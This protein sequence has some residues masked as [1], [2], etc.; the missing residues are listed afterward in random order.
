MSRAAG[1]FAVTL[2]VAATA[3]AWA[4]PISITTGAE[5]TD[6]E[7]YAAAELGD[8]LSRLTAEPISRGDGAGTRL[9]VG[10]VAATP[11]LKTFEPPVPAD[12]AQQEILIRSGTVGGTPAV[13]V[14]GGSPQAVLWAA[15]EL[16]EHLGVVFEFSGEILPTNTGPP[17]LSGIDIRRSPSIAERGLRLHLNFPMDQSAYS[18]PDFLTWVDRIARMKY[19]YLMLHFYAAHPW[20]HFKYRDAET[21]TGTFFVGSYMFGGRYD[22]PPDMIGRELIHNQA[23]FFP[24]EMEGMQQGPAL[25]RKTQERIRAVIDRAHARGIKVA[26]SFE[27]LGLPGDIGSHMGEW[28]KQAGGRDQLMR[29]VTT[30][31]L[32]ACMD[33]YPQADEYQLIS[34]EGSNDAPPGADLKAELR[35]LCA[36]YSIPFDPEDEGTFAG[37]RQ[38]G[39]N[40]TPYN[41]PAVS[42]ELEKG[43][44]RPVV[45]TLRFVDLALDVLA[46]PAVSSRMQREGKQGNVGIYLPH[47]NAVKLCTPALRAMMPDDARLQMMVDYGAR[48]TADQMPG[49]E[50]LRGANMQLGVITWL[51]FDGS[52]FLPQAWPRSVYDCVKSSAGLPLTT[53]VAN[54]WRVSGLE[55]DAACLAQTPWLVGESYGDWL[56]GYLDRLFGQQGAARAGEAYTALEDATLYCRAHLF[57][58]G[59]CWEGRYRQGFGYPPE[60]LGEARRRFERAQGGFRALARTQPEGGAKRRADYLA[61]RCRC[62]MVHLDT[63]RELAQAQVQPDDSPQRIAAC[64]DHALRARDLAREYMTTYAAFVLDRGDEGMLV[65]YH[66]AVVTRA[67]SMARAAQQIAVIAGADPAKPVMAWSFEQGDTRAVLD[68]TGNGFEAMCVGTVGFGPGKVG[69]CLRLDG[70]S[71]LRVDAAGGF[72][73]S[74]FTLCAWVNPER[75]TARRGIVAKRVGNVA[76][77]FVL[78]MQEGTLRFEGCGSSGTFWPFNF[79]GPDIP[80]GRWSHVAVTLESNNQIVLYVDGEPV[81]RKQIT[82]KP[83]PN[84]EPLVI[85]REAWGGEEGQASPALFRG[86]IDEVKVYKRALSADEVAALASG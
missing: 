47:G 40:L 25:Y 54:H 50:A 57:N 45:S 55:A 8:Y 79:S 34:V 75:A 51:E 53:L 82:E 67:E 18:L 59:F 28:E 39:I 26:L 10:T 73:P 11:D 44:Y 1:H 86:M 7:R 14:T 49:W 52:M 48:G 12:L 2:T 38:A 17:N 33:A 62:A 84:A 63:M 19:N 42:G 64:A 69:R 37:A 13:A 5:A 65:N 32:L 22:L 60:H 76:A 31:R 70:K 36:K 43:L 56:S 66:F 77:P 83:A 16:L 23:R 81:A 27:P 80:I 21:R 20:L 85:G 9:L 35:R 41:A 15:Y 30:A 71:H 4:T 58:V 72:N 24:P 29:Q 3:M 78:A 74:S 61:N 68:A 6:L 46:D